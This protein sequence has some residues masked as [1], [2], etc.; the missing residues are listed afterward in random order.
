MRVAKTAAIFGLIT[1]FGVFGGAW[2]DWIT[3]AAN[4]S[5]CPV[6]YVAGPLLAGVSGL[7]A[8]PDGQR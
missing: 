6:D 4:A 2:G 5:A 8:T 3:A 1:L 7:M